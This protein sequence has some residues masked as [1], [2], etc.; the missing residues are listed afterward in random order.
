MIPEKIL[1]NERKSLEATPGNVVFIQP[2]MLEMTTFSYKKANE[3][4]KI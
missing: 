3:L 1:E 2:D 4:I